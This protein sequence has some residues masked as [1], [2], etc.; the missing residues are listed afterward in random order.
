MST[1]VIHSVNAD[2]FREQLDLKRSS[3]RKLARHLGLDPSAIT[4]TFSGRRRMQ[5]DEATKIAQFL[6]VPVEEVLKNAGIPLDEKKGR[7]IKV[8]GDVLEDNE[9]SLFEAG[10]E[11]SVE[12]PTHSPEGT[13]SLRIRSRASF[14]DKAFV[15]YKAEDVINPGAIG[16][17]SVAKLRDG[18]SYLANISPGNEPGLYNLKRDHLTLDTVAMLESTRRSLAELQKAVQKV[19]EENSQDW[20]DQLVKIIA[21]PGN[22]DIRPSQHLLDRTSDTL[23]DVPLASASPVLWIRP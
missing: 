17:L 12:A 11:E 6:G 4:L 15:Y 2:W 10:F 22:H 23:R 5:L 1:S 7:R 13:V 21:V 19:V 9:L 16:R 14:L 18:K 8:I 3:Q 20:R